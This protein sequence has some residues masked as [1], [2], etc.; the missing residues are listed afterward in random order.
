MLPIKIAVLDNN[1]DLMILSDTEY[2]I[3]Y[4]GDILRQFPN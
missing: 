2:Y 3:A 4:K 1:A